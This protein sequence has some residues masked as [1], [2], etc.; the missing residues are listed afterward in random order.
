[1]NVITIVN[2]IP[3]SNKQTQCTVRIH[4]TYANGKHLKERK[5]NTITNMSRFLESIEI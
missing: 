3:Y 4:R 2:Y 1:M 5:T